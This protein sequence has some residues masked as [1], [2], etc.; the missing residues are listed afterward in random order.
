MNCQVELLD[1]RVII[2]MELTGRG[3]LSRCYVRDPDESHEPRHCK[4]L[5]EPL[6]PR[7]Q[8]SRLADPMHIFHLCFVGWASD[9]AVMNT[10]SKCSPE[11]ITVTIIA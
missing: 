5:S 4:W 6:T 7:V 8:S 2:C 1:C 3:A 11:Q 10:A 9:V